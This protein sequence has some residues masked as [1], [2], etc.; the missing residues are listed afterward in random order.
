MAAAQNNPRR[1]VHKVP[2]RRRPLGTIRAGELMVI[3]L[4]SQASPP[5]RV[6]KNQDIVLSHSRKWSWFFL[7]WAGEDACGP[8]TM[9]RLFSNPF[10]LRAL[11]KPVCSAT[12]DVSLPSLPADSQPRASAYH[13]W[14][15]S[16]RVSHVAPRPYELRP[17]VSICH[18]E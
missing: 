3:V 9:V 2:F 17:A 13:L 12:K 7:T 18:C 16:D 10:T 4:G 11:C 14:S 1:E 15:S 8:R 6:Q 5:T